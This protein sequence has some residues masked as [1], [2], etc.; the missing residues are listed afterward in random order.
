MIQLITGKI[1]GG[2]TVLAVERMFQY[3]LDGGTVISNIELIWH[4]VV[5]LGL[6]KKGRHILPEQY[7]HLDL[8]DDSIPWHH[9]IPWGTKEM[10]VQVYLDEVHLF[11]NSR[12]WQR[13][14][15][16][17]R[18]MLSFLSQ[19]RKACVD[20]SFIAQ[21][22]STL[23]RQFRVQCEWEIYVRNFKDI[24]IPLF[25]TLPFQRM[26]VT[27]KDN[28]TNYVAERTV[29][30]YPQ[31]IFPLYNT[32]DMLDDAMRD[33]AATAKIVEKRT[34]KRLTRKERKLILAQLEEVDTQRE[35]V[36]VE[37]RKKFEQLEKS[38]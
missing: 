13:T 8:N 26:L 2:K 35:I 38:A 11:F 17:H 15:Q 7:V 6:K 5:K 18:D 23:E 10:P 3:M 36:A 34:M 20:V 33:K 27:K 22:A 19:S 29:R 9:K 25:G 24:K 14:A 1:G 4:E 16:L 12:D 31:D 30:S 28:E 21:V 37:K 32:L